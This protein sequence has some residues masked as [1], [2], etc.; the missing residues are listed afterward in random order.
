M[1][2]LSIQGK[3]RFCTAYFH[4]EVFDEFRS[5]GFNIHWRVF[6]Y[7]KIIFLAVIVGITIEKYVLFTCRDIKL[8]TRA[9]D[10]WMLST[11]KFASYGG[12]DIMDCVHYVE[13]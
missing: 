4:L 5:A 13:N 2:H 7:V 3:D 9:R 8:R 10:M 12:F 1:N 6:Y 11:Y